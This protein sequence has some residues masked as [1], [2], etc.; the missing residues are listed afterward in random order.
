MRFRIS[1]AVVLGF[2]LPVFAAAQTTP[3][4]AT[5]I[6]ASGATKTQV[7]ASGTA[8]TVTTATAQSGTAYNAFSQFSL[9][10]GNTANLILPSGSSNL[11]NLVSGSTTQIY[12]TLNSL[13]AGTSEIGGN[14]Y[15]ADP[16]GIVIGST[17]VVNVGSLTLATP[18]QT[19][20]DQFLS[21]LTAF[22]AGGSGSAVSADTV[23]LP[24]QPLDPAGLISVLGE[25]HTAGPATLLAP[26]VNVSG[27]ITTGPNQGVFAGL[28]NTTGLQ[29]GQDI[30]IQGSTIAIAGSGAPAALSAGSGNINVA[31][32][33]SDSEGAANANASLTVDNAVLSGADI[34]LS[35]TATTD[36]EDTQALA[37]TTNL[38]QTQVNLPDIAGNVAENS[39]QSTATLNVGD[40]AGAVLNA[41]GN[42]SLTAE[43]DTTVVIDTLAPVGAFSYGSTQATVNAVLGSHANVTANGSFTLGATVNNTLDVEPSTIGPGTPAVTVAL[44]EASSSST[45]EL[46]GSVNAATIGI[47]ANNVNSFKTIAKA[48]AASNGMLGVGVAIGSYSSTANAV[49]NGTATATGA[50]ITNSDGSVTPALNLTAGSTNTDDRVESGSEVSSDATSTAVLNSTGIPLL[51]SINQFIQ[52]KVQSS[53]SSESG[54]S[55]LAISA[56]VSILNSVNTANATVN[57]TGKSTSGSIGVSSTGQDSP[58]SDASGSAGDSTVSI[59]GGVAY[60]NFSNTANT[61]INGILNG[62]TGVSVTA[63]ALLPNPF[64]LSAFTSLPGDFDNLNFVAPNSISDFGAYQQDWQA[65]QTLGGDIETAIEGKNGSGGLGQFLGEGFGLGENVNSFADTTASGSDSGG[66]VGVA[67]AVN[68]LAITNKANATVASGAQIS[69]TSGDADV[70]ANAN[71]FLINIAGMAFSP[72]NLKDFNPGASGTAAL[73]GAYNGVTLTNSAIAGIDGDAQVT[74]GGKGAVNVNGITNETLV[75]VTEAGSKADDLGVNGAFGWLTLGNT[76]I[77]SIDSDAIVNAAGAVNVNGKNTLNAITVGGALGISGKAEIGA[78]VDWNQLTNTTEAFIGSQNPPAIPDGTGSVTAGGPVS[79]NASGNESL[80]DITVAAEVATGESGSGDSGEGGGS[81]ESE[82]GDSGS[83]ASFGLGVSANVAINDVADTTLAYINNNAVVVTPSTIQV[84]A[85]DTSF[86]ISAGV[87][88]AVGT[89]GDVG[90]AVGGAFARNDISKDTEATVANAVLAGPQ[91]S[92]GNYTNA[93]AATVQATNRGAVLSIAAGVSGAT[94]EGAGIAGSANNDELTNTTNA[95]LE[96]GATVLA[97]GVTVNAAQG[98]KVLAIAGALSYG[99]NAGIGAA[100][101]LSNY[102]NTTTASV[103]QGATVT[104]GGNVAVTASTDEQ[105]LPV[106][107]ALGVSGGQVGIGG[108]ASYDQI[109]NDTEATI[110][111]AV[112]TPDNL[113]LGA[114]DNSQLLLI[115]GS[116][117]GADSVGL[118]LA[119]AISIQSHPLLDRTVKATV[120]ANANISAGGNGTPISYQGGN[121]DGLLASATATGGADT[122]V[123]GLAGSGD[124]SLAASLALNYFQADIESVIDNGA[125]VNSS[126]SGAAAGQNVAVNASDN[127]QILDVVGQLGGS[128]SAAIGAA[129]DVEFLNRTVYAGIGG[130]VQAENSVSANAN[131]GGS[132]W[133]VAGSANLGGAFSLAGA[134][135]AVLVSSHTTA[136]IMPD[137]VIYTPGSVLVNAQRSLNLHT[138]DGQI[139]GTLGEV[140]LG[141]SVSVVGLNATTTADVGAGASVTALGNGN[142]VSALL[143]DD[144]T[145]TPGTVNGLAVTADSNDTL[146][147]IAAGGAISTGV[148]VA[149]SLVLNNINE[150]T[151]AFVDSNAV[152][153]PTATQNL[154]NAA[155][156]VDILANNGTSLTSAAGSL[157]AGLDIYGVGVGASVNLEGIA[158]IPDSFQSYYNDFTSQES[159]DLSGAPNTPASAQTSGFTKLTTAG[160]NNGATVN[161]LGALNIAALSSENLTAYDIAVAAGAAGIDGSIQL[162]NYTPTTTAYF[163]SCTSTT[164]CSSGATGNVGSAAVNANDNFTY[165]SVLGG[166][167]VGAGAL[168]ASVLISTVAA[169]TSAYLGSLSSLTAGGAGDLALTSDFTDTYNS[170]ILSGGAGALALNVPY[171]SITDN[172]NNS[173]YVADDA[174]ATAGGALSLNATTS[175]TIAALSASA[176]VG[177]VAGGASILDVTFGGTT[178]ASLGNGDNVSGAG[179]ALASNLTDTIPATLPITSFAPFLSSIPGLSGI[180]APTGVLGAAAAG[181]GGDGAVVTAN[182]NGANQAE[183]GG[184]TVT[185]TNDIDVDAT[186][187]LNLQALSGSEQ[188][189]AAVGGASLATLNSQGSTTVSSS[190]SLT[191]NDGSVSLDGADNETL[192]AT[193]SGMGA[194]ALDGNGAVS[195]INGSSSNQTSQSGSINASQSASLLANTTR[196]ANS[197]SDASADAAIGVGV[198]AATFNLGGDTSSSL[199]GSVTATNGAI[200]LTAGSNDTGNAAAT[201]LNKGGFNGVGAIMGPVDQSSPVEINPT[202]TATLAGGA[203]ANAPSVNENVND[204][205]TLNGT[206]NGSQA[207]AVNVA[208]LEG[209]VEVNPS[210]NLNMNGTITGG[211]ANL[212]ATGYE[213][214]GMISN[215]T[216]SSSIVNGYQVDASATDAPTQTFTLDGAINAANAVTAASNLTDNAGAASNSSGSE[217]SVG[218]GGSSYSDT[219]INDTN[220]LNGNGSITVSNGDA[221]LS[222]TT[223]S[224]STYNQVTGGSGS[225]VATV[226]ALQSNNTVTDDT[227]LNFNGSLTAAQGAATLLAQSSVQADSSAQDQTSG[228]NGFDDLQTDA[229]TTVTANPTVTIGSGANL[230][231]QTINLQ[232]LDPLAQGSSYSDAEAQDA[233]IVADAT[234]DAT[235]TL[236]TNPT[237]NVNGNGSTGANLN[238]ATINMLTSVGSQD[239]NNQYAAYASSVAVSKTAAADGEASSNTVNNFNIGPAVNVNGG[240]TMTTGALNI[241]ALTPAYV[242]FTNDPEVTGV[243]VVTWVAT[244]VEETVDE[245]FGWIPF[246]G[247]LVKE[248]TKWVTEWVETITNSTVT[249][250]NYGQVNYNNQIALNGTIQQVEGAAGASLVIGSD[251]T[252]QP[253]SNGISIAGQDANTIL[254]GNIINNNKLNITLDAPNGTISGSP[255]VD[256]QAMLP[257]VNVTNNSNLNLVMQQISPISFS[258]TQP[259]MDITA[260]DDSNFTPNYQTNQNP[261]TITINNTGSGDVVFSAPINNMPGSLTVT[262]DGGDI[263]DVFGNLLQLNQT[264]LDAP[265][266]SVGSTEGSSF[267]CAFCPA[268]ANGVLALGPMDLQPS[269]VAASATA[270]PLIPTV[271]AVA[272]GDINLVLTPF[273]SSPGAILNATPE[274]DFG[275]LLAGDNINLTL[276]P[277]TIQG[278]ESEQVQVNFPAPFSF[279]D[280]TYTVNVPVSGPAANTNYA[281]NGGWIAGGGAVNIQG[282]GAAGSQ[283]TLADNGFIASGFQGL[284]FDVLNDGTPA[285]VVEIL[286][287]NNTTLLNYLQSISGP[288]VLSNIENVGAGQLNF[289][290]SGALAGSGTLG[291]LSGHT[292]VGIDNQTTGSLT[293]QN[294]LNPAGAGAIGT[295]NW[296]VGSGLSQ[297]TYGAA[298]GTVSLES[299]NDLILADTISAPNGA[300][301]ATSENGSIQA[302]GGILGGQDV[303][304]TANGSITG[305]AFIG[306]GQDATLTAGNSINLTAT[307]QSGGNTT[308]QAQSGDITLGTVDATGDAKLTA[309]NDIDLNGNGSMIANNAFLTAQQGTIN[310]GIVQADGNATLS[311]GQDIDFV[312]PNSEVIAENGTALLTAG[313]TIQAQNGVIDAGYDATLTAGDSIYAPSGTITAGNNATLT[314]TDAVQLGTVTAGE[315][316]SLTGADIDFGAITATAGDA[317]LTAGQIINGSGTVTAGQDATLLAGDSIDLGTVIAG[318]DASLTTETGPIGLGTVMAGNDATVNAVA[319]TIYLGTVTAGDSAAL[320]SGQDIDFSTGSTV[321]ATNGDATLTAGGSINAVGG[322]ISAGQDGS[323]LAGQDINLGTLTA[324]HD[325]SVTATAGNITLGSVTAGNDAGVNALAGRI[326]LGTVTAGDSATLSAGQDIDFNLSTGGAVTAIAGD[327]TLIAGGSINAAPTGTITAG[328]D[329]TLQAAQDISLGTLTAGHDAFLTATAGNIDFFPGTVTA[330]NNATLTAGTDID[331]NA[332]GVV[333]ATA[334]D[335]TL[336]AGGSINAGNGT[337]TAG[338]DGILT[339]GQQILLG[340]LTAGHD[341]DL[342]AG[343]DIDMGTLAAVHDA[344]ITSTSGNINLAPTGTITAGHDATLDA[345]SQNINLLGTVTAPNATLFANQNILGTGTVI[346]NQTQLTAVTGAIGVTGA[347]LN[348]DLNTIGGVMPQLSSASRFDS[349]LNLTDVNF[350][351]VPNSYNNGSLGGD[352]ISLL[353]GGNLNLTLNPGLAQGATLPAWYVI[354]SNDLAFVGGAANINLTSAPYQWGQVNFLVKGLLASGF[355]GITY[356]VSPTGS[357]STVITADG[358]T[359]NAPINFATIANGVINLSDIDAAQGG[360]INITGTGSFAGLNNLWASSGPASVTVINQDPNL[361]LQANDITLGWGQGDIDIQRLNWWTG[362]GIAPLFGS[363]NYGWS[364]PWWGGDQDKDSSHGNNQWPQLVLQSADSLNLAGTIANSHGNSAFTAAGT[365]FGSGL[366]Q[367]WLL[368]L[369]STAGGIGSAATPLAVEVP[370]LL[371]AS[372]AADIDLTAPAGDLVLGTIAT[373]GNINVSTPAGSI[374]NGLAPWNRWQPSPLNLSGNNITLSAAGWLG[375]YQNLVGSA[376]GLWNLTAGQGINLFSRG[377]LN[378]GAVSAPSVYLGTNGNASIVQLNAY[379][380]NLNVYQDGGSLTVGQAAIGDSLDADADNIA[381]AS[382]SHAGTAPLYLDLSGNHDGMAD[383]INLAVTSAAPV[384]VNSYASQNGSLTLAGAWLYVDQAAIGNAATFAS[385]WLSLALDN[386]NPHNAASAHLDMVGNQY[387]AHGGH[388]SI[389]A[390]D[391]Q[392]GLTFT[393]PS[394]P[395]QTQQEMLHE[396]HW[397]KW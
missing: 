238:A 368:N 351:G 43:G 244:Q 27:G 217:F 323:L 286:G 321:T 310:L 140:G 49:L 315:N 58:A 331:F 7:I 264:S 329:A 363:Y 59:G 196:T 332:S 21:D 394:S 387:S 257:F 214:A 4:A 164:D 218:Q 10:S 170:G 26:T 348:L 216:Q 190:G 88:L 395:T 109:A 251:G 209:S 97:N 200:T 249:Q 359:M 231:A 86:A 364:W 135:S 147:T 146:L 338:Y 222:A 355:D 81:A 169:N 390:A 139:S 118:G 54:S 36:S 89:G 301:L 66:S 163:G 22:S 133:S 391:L 82:S 274:V 227:E 239:P 236:T 38:T 42:V 120:G 372:A 182:E 269:E 262:N 292:N 71:A 215:S 166:A 111:G 24:T 296:T 204:T 305:P 72:D 165:A 158:S 35:A 195:A 151:Q 211:S 8:T 69:T 17:G 155:Q 381:I 160:V 37:I 349:N 289:S 378:A 259:A 324:G 47:S 44:G 31:A 294:L 382:L 93:G 16:S 144:G 173:A 100:L 94:G 67:G 201:G 353:T 388:F 45:A 138:I 317:L 70:N 77:G 41:T 185:A 87:A 267:A 343:S 18:N 303:N 373:P 279:L 6:T 194:G 318:H 252:V 234:A 156:A 347:D 242:N 240:V 285:S 168:G 340:T 210:L 376:T 396:L 275:Q 271:S 102:A 283:V 137:A 171:A 174:T 361:L 356:T 131:L 162:D 197:T 230:Q 316:A 110:D 308:L 191:S 287:Q 272:R 48:T 344:A 33:Q 180:T 152:I 40:T 333:T 345:L 304:F 328:Q 183:I 326:L 80:Y 312:S 83:E 175:R 61:T 280:Y 393:P 245:V 186:T 241:S 62:A 149:G 350:D 193:T 320:T 76:A 25:I 128:G 12:G 112:S 290:G 311:A 386:L 297:Q 74:T 124:V 34:N 205:T 99:G 73:G 145:A 157:A 46:D 78:T 90:V 235:L 57:G 30:T 129:A 130:N 334:G 229:T 122:I 28:V 299:F 172:S 337:I 3:P 273:E 362:T 95:E 84:Q 192:T 397:F 380:A 159:S 330:A 117:G 39:A 20:V 85:G 306:A 232:A 32:G 96:S 384:V 132:L 154:A 325:A 11:I 189:G 220:K 281:L 64:D 253:G 352:I 153:N 19:F 2:A 392:P 295:G 50:D 255:T 13:L 5:V 79:V 177:A 341:L 188:A 181:F 136:E 198:S 246:V 265:H 366:T 365:I 371:N 91:D 207:G 383:N 52:N 224:S 354:P 260:S 108:S 63:T 53:E 134:A 357:W 339:A 268:A 9:A 358:Q 65:A 342:T 270:Q 92:G 302:L 202:V 258:N 367:S 212:T 346:A 370:G 219:D 233:N 243:S 228:F 14:I 208:A 176:A 237:I 199:N 307:V 248:V 141:A 291:A 261:T 276:N 336:T 107:A 68:I 161:T 187:T 293:I 226:S 213:T 121:V 125:V 266:G 126:L 206:L 167:S 148:S 113:L 184:S 377:G 389:T 178:K 51:G 225:S 247:D 263:L 101:D 123:A 300:I 282:N 360:E 116:L 369:T 114:A 379:D 56:A 314:A 106:I 221:N 179:V 309:G 284:T 298:N 55:P 23:A 15:F 319:G 288:L 322:T 119:G 256:E 1:L 375:G 277:A 374:W 150:T 250:T 60:S 105:L 115:D 335:A 327:A 127:S 313:G 75:E 104:S 143:N 254:L 223:L 385:S 203:S 98:D 103:A 29:T 142:G 278:I